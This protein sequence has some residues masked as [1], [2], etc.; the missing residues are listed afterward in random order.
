MPTISNTRSQPGDV[1]STG[2]PRPDLASSHDA[3]RSD[4]AAAEGP[5]S[6]PDTSAAPPSAAEIAAEAHAIYLSR[7]GQHGRHDDDWFEAERRC[8]DRRR[9]AQQS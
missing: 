8:S 3:P 6:Y 4:R 2:A 5:V 1:D 9:Q 7:G